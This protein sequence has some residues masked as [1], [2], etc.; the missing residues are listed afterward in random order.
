MAQT[1]FE[2]VTSDPDKA[3]GIYY[4]YP[5][6]ESLNT[7]APKGYRPF[8]ISH[9]G[10]HGSRYLVNDR[11]YVDL[12]RMLQHAADNDALTTKGKMVKAWVDSVCKEAKGKA[13]E[14]TP[15]GNRQHH[16]IAVRMYKAFPEVFVDDADITATSTVVMRC[17]H[18]M[19]AFV[20]GLKEQNPSLNIPRDSSPRAMSYM[21][22]H[23]PECGEAN[24]PG[25]PWYQTYKNLD[26]KYTDAT[27]LSKE[28]FNSQDYVDKWVDQYYLMYYLF[29][30]AVDSQDIE[31]KLDFMSLFTPEELFNIW[32]A[33]N[34]SFFARNSTYAP[35]KGAHTNCDIPLVKNILETA[36]DYV[37]KGKTGATLR[38]GHDGNITP[39]AGLLKLSNCYSDAIEPEEVTKTWTDFKISPMAA[40]LQ[41]VFFKND[42]NDVICKFMLNEREIA[43]DPL[44][45]D[46]FPF[47]KWADVKAYLE[48]LVAE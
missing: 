28:L 48:G 3:G 26:K 31:T 38:F 19:F 6:T 23:N 35:A 40:N 10:R 45:T 22:H 42:K 32:E 41:I 30:Y 18:S 17:A 46:M 2:E 15:L 7:K 39:L 43:V 20:E 33:T 21:N 5:V 29:R 16:D 13:G 34:F 8:Y 24:G 47:Y 37:D 9:Y 11:D 27:R 25:N 12:P 4:A 14:L 44:K 1:S 36:N